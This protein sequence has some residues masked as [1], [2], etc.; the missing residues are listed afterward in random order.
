VINQHAIDRA[1]ER[2]GLRLARSDLQQIG[3]LIRGSKTVMTRRQR[4]GREVHAVQYLGVATIVLWDPR[5]GIVTFL[6]IEA[7]TA[8]AGLRMRERMKARRTA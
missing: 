2:Y 1:W 5:H 6:P 8:G 7:I 4:D 3:V